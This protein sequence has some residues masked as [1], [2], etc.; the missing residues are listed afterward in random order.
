MASI[1]F[2]SVSPPGPAPVPLTAMPVE[3]PASVDPVAS[4]L[5]RFRRRLRRPRLTLAER[6]LAA[7]LVILIVGGLVVGTWI[8]NTLESGIVDRTAA[9]TA[10]YVESFVAPHLQDLAPDGSLPAASVAQLDGLLKEGPLGDLI[11][12]L[13]VWSPGGTIVYGS[14]R[15]L[16]GQTFPIKGELADAFGGQVTADLSNLTASENTVE[17]RFWSRLLEMYLP[18][19]ESGSNKII[20]VVEFYQLPDAIDRE[21]GQAR[22]LSWGLVAAAIGASFLILFGIVKQGSDTIGRQESALKRQ[23]GELSELLAQ[24]SALNDRVRAA[25]ERTTTLN[26]RAL[27]RISADL[28]DGPGQTVALALM[29]FDALKA[30]EARE[31]GS[32][33]ELVEIESALQDA[34]RDMRAIAAGLRMPELAEL[35]VRGVTTRAVSD[36]IRRTGSPVAV[37]M[38]DVPDQVALPI[39]IALYRAIQELLSNA[40]R[41]GQGT[42]VRLRVEADDRFIALQVSD[43]GPGFDPADLATVPGLGLAGMREQAELLGGDFEISSKP[44]VGTET[45]IRWPL[46]RGRRPA[47][48]SQPGDRP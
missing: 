33:H 4:R 43:G 20:A 32:P 22:L 9:V 29:R 10:L 28:H 31:G 24:N 5:R 6:F 26:E 13:R 46:P 30:A 41:H 19:R 39:K 14:I 45:R 2:A 16:V 17:Q 34:L 21:V 1:R 11:V 48:A 44:G 23:V 35:D 38:D 47:S 3:A 12:S 36:H 15:E 42:D 8:G 37:T 40:F 25:A 7:N 18:V 27:R